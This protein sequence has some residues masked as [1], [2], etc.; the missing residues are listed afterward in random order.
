MCSPS[1][2]SLLTLPQKKFEIHAIGFVAQAHLVRL[3][4]SERLVMD[5][6]STMFGQSVSEHLITLVT[7]AD[8]QDNPPVVEAMQNYGVKFKLSLKFNNSTLSNTKSEEV[9]D[10]DRVYWRV[11]CRNWKKCLKTLR[12]LP[13]LSVNTMKAVQ[14]EIYAATVIESAEKDLRA[15]LKTFFTYC[16]KE[17]GLFK[18]ALV[19]C[20]QIWELAAVVHRLKHVQNTSSN[21]VENIMVDFANET[22]KALNISPDKYLNLLSLAPS[23]SLT[24]GGSEIIRSM[25]MIYQIRKNWHKDSKGALVSKNITECAYCHNCRKEHKVKRFEIGIKKYIPGIGV[26]ADL[27]AF[28][29]VECK[30]SGDLHGISEVESPFHPRRCLQDTRN[31]LR[32]TL[33]R[34]SFPGYAVEER[35][36]LIHLNQHLYCEHQEFIRELLNV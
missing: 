7:F 16:T 21:S 25:A 9:D 14:S 36:F 35:R 30:C 17:P 1:R 10:L 18:E 29:C 20:E 12:D 28:K 34:H 27:L 33:T 5:Y 22:C 26:G 13:P 32:K 19:V 24:V 3:T 11:C 8:N 2:L 15:E 6:I 23:R 31:L 4:S